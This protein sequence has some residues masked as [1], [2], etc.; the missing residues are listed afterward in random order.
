MKQVL[1]VIW[2]FDSIRSSYENAV[3]CDRKISLSSLKV[4]GNEKLGG[5]GICLLLED[6]FGLWRS[7]SV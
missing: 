2:L 6:V 1:Y 7:M 4:V 3:I 5:S